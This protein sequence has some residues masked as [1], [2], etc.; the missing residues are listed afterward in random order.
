MKLTLK[1]KCEHGE[2]GDVIDVECCGQAHA[3]M[4]DG[5]VERVTIPSASPPKKKKKGKK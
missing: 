2:P 5:I 4:A 1:C 3:M